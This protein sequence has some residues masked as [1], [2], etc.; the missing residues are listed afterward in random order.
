MRRCS[1]PTEFD[2]AQMLRQEFPVGNAG[3]ALDAGGAERVGGE[4][5]E[6]FAGE[7]VVAHMKV[8][9]LDDELI[10]VDT[11]G[12]TGEQPPCRFDAILLGGFR[13]ADTL[14][15]PANRWILHRV[16]SACVVARS[17]GAVRARVSGAV[18]SARVGRPSS[19]RRWRRGWRR[20]PAM[21]SCSDRP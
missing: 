16:E 10:G 17:A 15:E 19:L 21:A 4:F 18:A 6:H 13:H 14:R 8:G 7:G 3:Y 2:L 5:H 20:R 11:S 12:E 9:S 1:L